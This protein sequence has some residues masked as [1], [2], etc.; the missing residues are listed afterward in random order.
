MDVIESRLLDLKSLNNHMAFV[1]KIDRWATTVIYLARAIN[2]KLK[3]TT[4]SGITFVTILPTIAGVMMC[5][6]IL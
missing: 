3:L 6:Q 4:Q 2:L 5:C 1:V